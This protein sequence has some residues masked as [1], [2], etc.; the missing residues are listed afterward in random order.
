MKSINASITT[1]KRMSVPRVNLNYLLSFIIDSERI[2][3]GYIL[4]TSMT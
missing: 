2:S 4:Y 1:P 3:P